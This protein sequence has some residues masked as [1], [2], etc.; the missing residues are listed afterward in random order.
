MHGDERGAEA[1]EAGEVLVAAGLVDPPLAPQ[2]GLD[3]LHRDAV[4]LH[5]A[6]AAALADQLVDDDP[7]VRVGELAPLAPAPLLGGTGLVVDQGRDPGHGTELPLDGVELVAVMHPH[8]GGESGPRA[9]TC[10]A[11]R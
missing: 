4:R 1:L 11:R 2:L 8:A 9:G 3:R 7:A 5:A 6:V 10:P